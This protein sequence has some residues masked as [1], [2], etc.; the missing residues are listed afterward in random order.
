MRQPPGYTYAYEEQSVVTS[1]VNGPGSL[2]IS[3][4]NLA[5]STGKR[6]FECR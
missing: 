2:F 5:S 3:I 1:Q 6:H 4:V